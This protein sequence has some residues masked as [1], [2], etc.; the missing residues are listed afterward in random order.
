MSPK[1]TAAVVASDRMNPLNV[2]PVSGVS[3]LE[4]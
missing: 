3:T 4:C 1:C 2:R